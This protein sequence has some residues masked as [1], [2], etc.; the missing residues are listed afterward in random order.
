MYASTSGDHT[1][2]D[3][4]TGPASPLSMGLH[5]WWLQD[6]AWMDVL[7]TKTLPGKKYDPNL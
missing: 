6:G 4:E 2:F 5:D 1:A 3:V 7:S